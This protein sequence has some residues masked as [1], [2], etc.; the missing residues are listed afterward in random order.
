MFIYYLSVSHACGP[1][2]GHEGAQAHLPRALA[3]SYPPSNLFLLGRLAET[4]PCLTYAQAGRLRQY[5]TPSSR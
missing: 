3:P 4:T 2:Q 5:I 1:T